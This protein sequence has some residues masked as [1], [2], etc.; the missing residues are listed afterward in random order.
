MAIRILIA[1]DSKVSLYILGQFIEGLGYTVVGEVR[2]GKAAVEAAEQMRPDL[3][4]LDVVMPIMD[5]YQACSIIQNK[6]KIP[7]ILVTGHTDNKN[8]ATI[9]D[10]SPTGV[11]IKPVNKIQ[12][13]ATIRLILSQIH[14]QKLSL[15]YRNIVEFAPL[16]VFMVDKSYK[17]TLVN[18]SFCIALELNKSDILGKTT[19]AILGENSFQQQLERL[20][21]QS[22]SGTTV[23]HEHWYNFKHTGKR[24]MSISCFP[25]R[26]NEEIDGVVVSLTDITEL[27][28]SKILLMEA[29]HLYRDLTSRIPGG[30]YALR[31]N[32]SGERIF[33]FLSDP[34]CDMLDINKEDALRASNILYDRIHPDDRPNLDKADRL[35]AQTLQPFHW[36]GRFI[37]RGKIRWVQVQSNA[38]KLPGGESLWNGILI[39]ITDQII[40]K[41]ELQE[42]ACTDDLTGLLNRRQFIETG[43]QVLKES[44]TTCSSFVVA[45]VDID[46][47]KAVND[48]YGHSAGDIVLIEFSQLAKNYF[49]SSDIFGRIGGEEFGIV[50]RQ[51]SSSEATNIIEHFRMTI[52]QTPIKYQDKIIT[53]T[54][55]C[56]ICPSAFPGD[57]FL[58]LLNKADQAL[59]KAKELGRN[60]V[61]VF[62]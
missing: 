18:K 15:K 12:L 5:G 42:R 45:M 35:A 52:A 50:L 4:V 47:F 28:K 49:R 41:N 27:K 17:Y 21:D 19:S 61:V 44:T 11:I 26:D 20:I 32:Q 53:I 6:L 56:G 1:D 7:V 39:D 13:Q 57:T 43:D 23:S 14:A 31:M 34:M 60:Q 62:S 24:Y 22:F 9:I 29:N 10:T 58:Q 2:D 33:E 8:M 48:T 46:Y 16:M 59:Y 25:Y 36:E 55:S 30:V 3:V 37:I 38:L 51:S 40:Q 54:I